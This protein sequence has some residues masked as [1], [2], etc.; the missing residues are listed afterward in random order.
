MAEKKCCGKMRLQIVA[1]VY[2]MVSALC[3]TC[4]KHGPPRLSWDDAVKAHLE[5]NG[6]KQ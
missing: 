5:L 4:G 6:R 2:P 1:E 3:K